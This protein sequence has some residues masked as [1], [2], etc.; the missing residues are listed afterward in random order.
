MDETKDESSLSDSQIAEQVIAKAIRL[1]KAIHTDYRR[2]KESLEKMP[3]ALEKIL[4]TPN[5]PLA[6]KRE[7]E[8]VTGNV[9]SIL[10]RYNCAKKYWQKAVGFYSSASTM[11]CAYAG[12]GIIAAFDSKY[13]MVHQ[14][15]KLCY[16]NLV[17]AAKY[18]KKI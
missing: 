4:K 3:E 17:L 12:L 16:K 2:A 7:V 5:I 18:G 9:Y 14:N 13:D 10:H 15:A 11:S 1:M 8:N 6:Q